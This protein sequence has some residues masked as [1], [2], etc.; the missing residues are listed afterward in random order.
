MSGE[1]H[2]LVLYKEYEHLIYKKKS[3]YTYVYIYIQ[4]V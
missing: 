3:I 1:K 4:G 2:M